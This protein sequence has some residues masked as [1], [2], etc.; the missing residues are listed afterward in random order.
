MQITNPEEFSQWLA[1]PLTQEFLG[2]LKAR[3]LRLTE[4]WGAGRQ[5]T[6]E[7]QAQAV[8]LGQLARLRFSSDGDEVAASIEDLAGIEK[9]DE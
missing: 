3:H 6:A 2:L 9:E 4:A 5:L 7:E 8:L 1:N